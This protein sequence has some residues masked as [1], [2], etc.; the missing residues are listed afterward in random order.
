MSSRDDLIASFFASMP[1]RVAEATELWLGVEQ[2]RTQ[3][4]QV[5]RRMLH[6]IKGEAHML[7]LVTC[8]DLAELAESVVDAL[9]KVGKP[10]QLTG[11]ALLGSFEGMGMVSAE[12]ADDD[13][14]LLDPL[15]AQLRAAIAELETLAAQAPALP[16]AEEPKA[17]L[18]PA[19]PERELAALRAEEVRPL[20]HELRR[21]YG[22][23]TVFH[24]R[25]R[26]MQRM[27]RALL[28]ELDVRLTPQSLVERI[29]KTLG[30]GAEID[31]GM[32]AVRAGWSGSEFAVGL[33]LDELERCVNKASVVS[34]E[35]LLNQ[36]V[37]V[38]RSTARTLNKDVDLVVSGDA[39]LDAAIERRLEQALLHLVRNAIDHGVESPEA[40]KARGKSGRPRIEVTLSHTNGS[41]TAR[42]ADDG[43]G[44]DTERLR[45][46]LVARGKSVEGLKSEELLPYLFEQGVTTTTEVTS[47]SGRGVGLDVVAREVA[48]AG[49]QV[50]IESTRE[51][52]TRVI[53]NLPTTLKGEVAVP[54]SVGQQQYAV[55]ARAVYSVM[56][57]E[58]IEQTASGDYLRLETDAGQEL[59]RLYSLA[60]L[61]G[62]SSGPKVGEAALILFHASGLF[63]V[64]VEGYDNPR[65]ITVQ[66]AEEMPFASALVRGASPTPDGGVLLLLDVDA[67]H[68]SARGAVGPSRTRQERALVVEDAPVARELLCG[69]LR[70]LG[71]SV[72]EAMDG[73]EGLAMAQEE[74]PDLLLT[75]IEMPYLDG[76]SMVTAL[77]ALPSFA[78]LP[79]IV[80][81][82]AA[83]ELN[84]Q[85]LEQLGVVAVLA[86]QRFDEAE[87][88]QLVEKCLATRA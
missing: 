5:L 76:I 29:T 64:S 13:Q 53:L 79:V 52:G 86:K 23:Q 36:V 32:S 14:R 59:V 19:P 50:R 81:S 46:V 56:R 43:A 22:E 4:L 83:T 20:V 71:L 27:L 25:L 84:R 7:E 49:G 2:G 82:T 54:I 61:L 11:D 24:E 33:T 28:G 87:L 60:A 88:K 40:R 12:S 6:T 55:P 3:N 30:Y 41:V 39:I 21:L 1:A 73:R 45:A 68:A 17:P 67:L 15:K 10:T 72:R 18:E 47:I 57:L 34:T 58:A 44:V 77:R 9:R 78:R 37:R 69:I 85:R 38:G 65:P 26:E 8:G 48:A 75:D 63:A 66:R 42:V 16:A 35:R 31:R 80:L 70:S 62:G 51:L 74:P